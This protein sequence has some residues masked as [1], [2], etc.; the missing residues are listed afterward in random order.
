MLSM[1]PESRRNANDQVTDFAL[2][3]KGREAGEFRAGQ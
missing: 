3:A 1:S 2:A